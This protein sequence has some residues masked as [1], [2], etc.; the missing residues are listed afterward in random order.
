MKKFMQILLATFAIGVLAFA[1][2]TADVEDTE[3]EATDDEVVAEEVIEEVAE[4]A[5]VNEATEE[6]V[7]EVAEEVAEEVTE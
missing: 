1:G 2:C 6:V 7:E 4:E 5:A 3:T